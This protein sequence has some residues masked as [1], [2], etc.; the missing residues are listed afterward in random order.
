[1]KSEIELECHKCKM[2]LDCV[3]MSF[4]VQVCEDDL[5]VT[6]KNCLYDDKKIEYYSEL[7]TRKAF[8]RII[9]ES[10]GRFN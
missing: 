7:H 9:K 6:C 2:D 4:E 8:E 3:C 5:L 10:L 1:M